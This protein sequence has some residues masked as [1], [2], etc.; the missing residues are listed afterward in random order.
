MDDSVWT[1]KHALRARL[2]A[3]RKNRSP[4]SHATET[5]ALTANL[6]DL[7]TRLGATSLS[8]YLSGETEPNTRPFLNWAFDSSLRVL[9]PIVREDGL[10]DWAVGDGETEV[11]GPFGI[12]EV[13]GDIQPPMA[14]NTVDLILA[15]ALAVDRSGNRLGQGR[16]YYDKVLG[17]MTRCPPVYAVV[18]DNEL[19]DAVPAAPVDRHV[20]GAVTPAGI[21]TFS[22]R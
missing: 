11:T 15:P 3:L 6:I 17:S 16:G 22:R 13:V 12:P 5:A 7:V 10:L 8:C 19:V 2:R 4:Q 20:D 14:I 9:F 18:F 21:V 1:E